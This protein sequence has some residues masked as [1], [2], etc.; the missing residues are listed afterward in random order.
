[1]SALG[2]RANVEQLLVH[3]GQHYYSAMSQVFFDD[4]G[5][6]RADVDLG[7]GSDRH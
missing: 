5:I 1:M 3:T 7:I 6:P 2:R 4:L